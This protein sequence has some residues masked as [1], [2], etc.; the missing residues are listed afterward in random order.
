MHAPAYV[1]SIFALAFVLACH[2]A[3]SAWPFVFAPSRGLAWRIIV[4][5]VPLLVLSLALPFLCMALTWPFLQ[6]LLRMFMLRCRMR[7]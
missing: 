7:M 6:C 4:R 2:C 3:S 1:P 5:L